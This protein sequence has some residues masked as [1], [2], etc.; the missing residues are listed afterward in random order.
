VLLFVKS[1]S[2]ANTRVMRE[3]FLRE[4]HYL[5]ITPVNQTNLKYEYMI[6]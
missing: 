3:I 1:V 6:K 2:V 4:F 5:F